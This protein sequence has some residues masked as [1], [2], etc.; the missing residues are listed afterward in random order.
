MNFFSVKEFFYKLN[1]I[2]FIL[3]LLPLGLFVFL[4][5]YTLD[6]SPAIVDADQL[7]VLFVVLCSVVIIVLTIVHWLRR[8][9]MRRLKTLNE[10]AKK[11]DGY[12]VLFV[13]R[14]G[15]YAAGSL[16]MA[17]GYYL[18]HSVYFTGAFLVILLALVAQWPRPYVFCKDFEL[19]GPERD[20]VLHNR[21]LVR[22]PSRK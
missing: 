5:Y 10:L 3:L 20:L 22:K 17:I 1:T 18:T 11:M 15:A 6:T 12:F 19:R 9:R 14:N 7:A 2:G 16:L 13:V 8:E 21:D 4:H